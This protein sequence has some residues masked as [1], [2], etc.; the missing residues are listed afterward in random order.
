MDVPDHPVINLLESLPFIR[1]RKLPDWV[2]GSVCELHTGKARA[3]ETGR[4]P[5]GGRGLEE[6]PLF[7]ATAERRSARAA[8]LGVED[9]PHE[10]G[11]WRTHREG[12]KRM[13]V[14]VGGVIRS[15]HCN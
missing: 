2:P 15:I 13:L 10:E 8:G 3:V 14:R 5:S 7:A 6:R 11:E 4:R 9:A 1:G 12:Y